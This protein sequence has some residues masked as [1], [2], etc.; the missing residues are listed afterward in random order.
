MDVVGEHHG[1]GHDQKS[2]R[3]DCHRDHP[4]QKMPQLRTRSILP[5]AA[6]KASPGAV[7]G[8]GS[9]PLPDGLAPMRSRVEALEKSFRAQ[10]QS[11]ARLTEAWQGAGASTVRVVRRLESLEL[12]LLSQGLDLDEHVRSLRAVEGNAGGFS[13]TPPMRG[14]SLGGGTPAS[15]CTSSLPVPPCGIGIRDGSNMESRGAPDISDPEQQERLVHALEALPH[16]PIITGEASIPSSTSGLAGEA[17]PQSER[18]APGRPSTAGE[19][20]SPSSPSCNQKAISVANSREALSDVLMLIG[21]EKD[22][23]QARNVPAQNKPSG[24][25]GVYRQ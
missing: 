4:D 12:L 21:M 23:M 8:V 25:A 5:W 17:L 20:S 10:E 3:H 6:A 16:S 14:G 24:S 18:C 1:D 19:A 11:L 2:S 22:W 13:L 15:S 7:A 9:T